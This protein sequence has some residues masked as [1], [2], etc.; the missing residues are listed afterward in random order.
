MCIKEKFSLDCPVN[1]VNAAYLEHPLQHT[2]IYISNNM[3]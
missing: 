2:K 3:R 1:N